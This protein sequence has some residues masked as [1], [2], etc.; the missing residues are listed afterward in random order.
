MT[1]VRDLLVVRAMAPR[2]LRRHLGWWVAVI[3]LGAG[4]MALATLTARVIDPA[5]RTVAGDRG[6]ALILV[7]PTGQSVLDAL[8]IDRL[9][10]LPQVSRVTGVTQIPVRLVGSSTTYW[11]TPQVDPLAPMPASGRVAGGVPEVFVP[12]SPGAPAPALGKATLVVSGRAGDVRTPVQVVGTFE[13][14]ASLYA[15]RLAILTSPELVEQVVEQ[16]R[17]EGAGA[18]AYDSAYVEASSVGSVLALERSIRELGFEASSVVGAEPTLPE[19][20]AVLGQATG[21]V[22]VLVIGTALAAGAVVGA[23]FRADRSREVG[24]LR[25]VG[26]TVGRVVRV[27][28]VEVAAVTLLAAVSAVVAAQIL[29]WFALPLLPSVVPGLP[30][31]HGAVVD[32]PAALRLLVGLPA[33]GAL[34]AAPAVRALA[35][36]PPDTALRSLR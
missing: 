22:A 4:L 20:L 36:M 13:D 21:W 34:G 9:D 12:T 26:W 25:A 10:A 19:G 5:T 2:T 18:I 17:G 30:A 32:G 16:G 23:G 7:R 35:V 27:H 24:V 33:G 11:L 15:G 31:I 14:D 28:L 29:C 1:R 6:L 3:V 8:A